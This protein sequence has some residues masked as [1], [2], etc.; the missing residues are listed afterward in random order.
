M[1][2]FCL[3]ISLLSLCITTYA[4]SPLSGFQVTD[5][6]ESGE[7]GIQINDED[8]HAD[9]TSEGDGVILDNETNDSDKDDQFDHDTI[10]DEADFETDEVVG[11][12]V[13]SSI[14]MIAIVICGCICVERLYSSCKKVYQ[15]RTGR[16]GFSRLQNQTFNEFEDEDDGMEM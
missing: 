9:T 8:Q 14:G 7:G 5:L 3:F 2:K 13:W 15:K 6:P 10:Y 4:A 1:H 16:Y 12:G 11:G